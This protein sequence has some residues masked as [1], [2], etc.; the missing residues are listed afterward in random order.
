MKGSENMSYN[1]ELSREEKKEIL[2]IANFIC[3]FNVQKGSVGDRYR[4]AAPRKK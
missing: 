3:D 4:K 2:E 1:S